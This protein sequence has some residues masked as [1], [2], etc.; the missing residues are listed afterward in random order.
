MLSRREVGVALI[1]LS[2]APDKQIADPGVCSIAYSDIC[3]TYLEKNQDHQ[4]HSTNASQTLAVAR[5]LYGTHLKLI[6]AA[7]LEEERKSQNLQ[8]EIEAIEHGEWDDKLKAAIELEK[9]TSTEATPVQSPKPLD[10]H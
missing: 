4:S 10:S 1:E 5:Q 7:L 6:A 9:P 3:K 8:S 2:L